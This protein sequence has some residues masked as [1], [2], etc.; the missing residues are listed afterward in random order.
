MIVTLYKNCIVNNNYNEVFDVVPRTIGT[1]QN[2]TVFEQYLA[3]LEKRNVVIENAYIT[4]NGFINLPLNTPD[5]YEFNYIKFDD[6]VNVRYCFIDDVVMRNEVAIVYY[7]EDVW[8]NYAGTMHIRNSLLKH[9]RLLVYDKVI[10]FYNIPYQYLGNNYLSITNLDNLDGTYSILFELQLYN[11]TEAGKENSRFCYIALLDDTAL[12][13][14]GVRRALQSLQ[15]GAGTIKNDNEQYYE[16]GNV[17]IIP[18]I[19]GVKNKF[20]WLLASV[21]I[22]DLQYKYDVLNPTAVNIGKPVVLNS[23]SISNNFKNIAIGTYTSQFDI[24]TN[25]TQLDVKLYAIADVFSFH[26]Y[27][28]VQNKQ[29]DITEQFTSLIPFNSIN[30]SETAQ[31]QLARNVKNINGALSLAGA[32]TASAT[33]VLDYQKASA[34]PERGAKQK[35]RKQARL[36]SARSNIIGGIETTGNALIDLYANNAPVYQ[37]N[38]GNFAE[39]NGIINAINGICLFTLNP[40]NEA[41]VTAMIDNLGYETNEIVGDVVQSIDYSFAHSNKFNVMQF[42]FINLYGNFTQSIAEALKTIMTNGVKIWY[43][44]ENV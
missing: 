15:T 11:L 1:T 41:Q 5:I 9:S 4:N 35:A 10:Q 18:S 28:G 37:S 40:D 39:S 19:Y 12:D 26:F 25:G 14:R 30:G 32:I 20:D 6:G 21:T 44:W 23:Y 8:H 42:G 33:G 27:I 2:T 13:I 36:T 17:Y 38:I 16:I 29:I 22:G 3:T 24:E 31:R 7:S 34:L 43:D